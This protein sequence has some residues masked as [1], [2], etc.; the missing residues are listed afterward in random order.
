MA[1]FV[2]DIDADLH[3]DLVRLTYQLEGGQHPSAPPPA[4]VPSRS[5]RPQPLQPHP[6]RR[7]GGADIRSRPWGAPAP[8]VLAA[9]YAA[10][11]LEP[12]VRPRAFDTIRRAMRW[13]G[14]V[15]DG[16][17]HFLSGH[18]GTAGWAA[19][20][21]VDPIHWALGAGFTAVDTAG[22]KDVQR[23]LPQPVAGGP[24]RS[25]RRGHRRGRVDRRAHR[26]PSHP[27]REVRVSDD[28]PEVRHRV[29]ARRCR[30]RRRVFS[31]VD[32]PAKPAGRRRGAPA[33]AFAP[34]APRP[35]KPTVVV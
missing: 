14:D 24:S 20:D 15:D 31:V 8:Q 13:R 34:R 17:I 19:V 11:R 33:G 5:D 10:G 30:L 21:G 1:A 23:P 6:H 25:R 29:R 32:R 4:P 9:M 26:S 3:A 16:L 28:E 22:R 18:N 7:R 12:M 2:Y 27:P 35:G